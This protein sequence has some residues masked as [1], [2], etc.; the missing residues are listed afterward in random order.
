MVRNMAPDNIAIAH[1]L[2]PSEK[3]RIAFMLLCC[4]RILTEVKQPAVHFKA[5][6]G[7]FQRILDVSW[8]WMRGEITDYEKE[9]Y[10]L[11]MSLESFFAPYQP[12]PE[13]NPVDPLVDTVAC[14]LSLLLSVLRDS[15]K[16]AEYCDSV[17]W[18]VIQ[19]MY[20]LYGGGH[21]LTE[22]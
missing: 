22:K 20:F 6:V 21:D 7:G 2:L 19:L 16:A 9:I 1:T 10:P 5:E 15:S 14:S 8:A 18:H 4:E 3:S 17:S 11:H 12:N 13:N